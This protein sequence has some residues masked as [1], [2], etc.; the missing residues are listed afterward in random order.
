MGCLTRTSFGTDPRSRGGHRREPFGELGEQPE[1]KAWSQRPR[2]SRKL[3][4]DKDLPRCPFSSCFHFPNPSAVLAFLGPVRR[5]S[6]S[7]RRTATHPSIV[8]STGRL[9]RARAARAVFPSREPVGE[10][11]DVGGASCYQQFEFHPPQVRGHLLNCLNT[12]K[13]QTLAL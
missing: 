5:G 1:G 10:R 9:A 12:L 2:S 3:V 13:N 8:S 6:G 7:R 11:R 4:S